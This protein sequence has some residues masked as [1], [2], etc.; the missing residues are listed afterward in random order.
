VGERDLPYGLQLAAPHQARAGNVAIGIALT[1]ARQD[2][3]I[4]KHFE[5]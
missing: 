5:P 1:H 3:S 2:L 4:L